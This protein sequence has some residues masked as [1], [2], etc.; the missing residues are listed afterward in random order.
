V[1]LCALLDDSPDLMLFGPT[2]LTCVGGL[3]TVHLQVRGEFD[4]RSIDTAN[5]IDG[6]TGNPEAERLWLSGLPL[7]PH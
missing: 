6:C 4:G 1:K 2:N 7:P 5:G 3:G